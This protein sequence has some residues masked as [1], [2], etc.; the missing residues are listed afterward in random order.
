MTGHA[1]A[2]I[3]EFEVYTS[4]SIESRVRGELLRAQTNEGTERCCGHQT[5]PEGAYR[6]TIFQ[7]NERWQQS[8]GD[9]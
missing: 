8:F 7:S 1:E 2:D 3:A 9:H 6:A 5:A 4:L